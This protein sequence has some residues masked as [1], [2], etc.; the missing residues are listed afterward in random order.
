LFIGTCNETN[1]GIRNELKVIPDAQ[2]TAS[3]NNGNN[4][5]P[6]FGRL[7][8]TSAWCPDTD[9][10]DG[11]PY[12]EINLGQKYDICGVEVQGL[13]GASVTTNFTLSYSSDNGSTFVDI[14]VLSCS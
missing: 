10:A 14:Q 9:P 8:G 7:E 12:L 5:L 4:F 6:E 11:D 13:P 1:V 3:S 2:M